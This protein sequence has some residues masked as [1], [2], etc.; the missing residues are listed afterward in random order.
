M[1][2]RELLPAQFSS[3]S[4]P[5]LLTYHFVLGFLLSLPPTLTSGFTYCFLCSSFQYNHLYASPLWCLLLVLSSPLALLFIMESQLT[6]MK[7]LLQKRWS[8]PFRGIILQ[9]HMFSLSHFIKKVP[10]FAEQQTSFL[11]VSAF[12]LEVLEGK[13]HARIYLHK[14][15]TQGLCSSTLRTT[16]SQISRDLSRHVAPPSLSTFVSY[17]FTRFVSRFPQRSLC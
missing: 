5:S 7:V 11:R 17:N 10:W 15:L 1:S 13:P 12:I 8:F 16:R 4:L 2:L 9:K 3:V 14:R 6:Q